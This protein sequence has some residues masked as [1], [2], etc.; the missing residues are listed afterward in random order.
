[1]QENAVINVQEV[2][3]VVMELSNKNSDILDSTR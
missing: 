1:M 3:E 2:D